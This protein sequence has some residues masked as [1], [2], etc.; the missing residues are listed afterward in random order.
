MYRASPT[1]TETVE[2]RKPSS[3]SP[4]VLQEWSALPRPPARG[5]EGE[6][7]PHRAGP[8]HSRHSGGPAGTRVQRG[9]GG[10]HRAQGWPLRGGGEAG[11]AQCG[12]QPLLQDIPA[13]YSPVYECIL[14]YLLL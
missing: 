14:Y 3:S 9:Q 6:H 11:G 5:P 2:R 8:G 7:H 13:R 4:A 10:L 1:F 12:L